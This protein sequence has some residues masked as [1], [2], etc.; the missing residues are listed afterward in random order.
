MKKA[1]VAAALALCFTKGKACAEY[2]P[3]DNY[4]SLFTQS[5]IK[6]KTYLPFLFSW[7]S[8]FYSDGVKRMVPDENIAAWRKYFGN[9]LDYRETEHLVNHMP[10][11]ELQAYKN[12]SGQNAVL[13]KL[14]SYR[15]VAEG[16]DYLLEAKYL[17]PYMKI[18][19]ADSENS[20]YEEPGET[21]KN[22]SNLEYDET[23]ANLTSLY[24][25]AQNREI[26]Q[27]YGYQ[28]VRFHH[29]TR[30]YEQ[31]ISAFSKY[32]E[33]LGKNTVPYFLALD[34]MAGAQRGLA[35]NRE[36]NWNFFRVF[37]NAPS[38]KE[39]AFVS[40]KISDSAAFDNILKKTST[41]E[42]KNMAYFLLGY[43]DFTNP[44]PNMEKMYEIDPKS[45]ILKVMA[46]RT[47]HILEI[48]YLRA[49]LVSDTGKTEEPK[50]DNSV[51]KSATAKSEGFWDQVVGFFQ[52]LFGNKK[53]APA[54]ARPEPDASDEDLTENPNRIP[55]FSSGFIGDEASSDFLDDFSAFTEKTKKASDDEFWQITDAYV[56][57]LQ[58]DYDKSTEVL[59][60]IQTSNPEY[61]EQITRMKMLNR[62]TSQP[63][64]DAA[65]ESQIQKEYPDLFAEK[66]KDS[67][68]KYDYFEEPTT[69]DFIRDVLANRY[70]L[71]NEDG[72]SFLMSNSFSDLQY[73]PDVT[74]T[75]K[76]EEF[77]NKPN[78]TPLEQNIIMQNVDV[79][80]HA[81]FAN[82]IYGDQ[83]MRNGNFDKAK[84]YYAN[85]TGFEGLPRYEW[86]FEQE[87]VQKNKVSQPEGLYDGFNNISPLVFGHNVWESFASSADQSMVAEPFAQEYPFLTKKM[88]KLQLAGALAELKK[89]NT[90]KSNQLIGNVL[91]NTSSLGYFR[92][93]FIMDIDNSPWEKN[94]IQRNDQPK[95]QY[96]Y[97]SYTWQPAVRPDNF[98]VAL[99]FYQNALKKSTDREQKA[100]ILFQMASV[101]QGKYY[102][103]EK[104]QNF[105]EN[106][107]DP[108]WEAKWDEYKQKLGEH[109]NSAYRTYFAQIKNQFA[110]TQTSQ[111]LKGSCSYY[112]YF[113]SK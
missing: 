81:A 82:V 35:M 58:K 94:D 11:A 85:A 33:P 67:A 98:D 44:I 21:N 84:S 6:D 15:T 22:A 37:M 69:A 106:Y 26:K 55:V 99:G 25:A 103:W 40:M 91:Y 60:G 30:N 42:E 107:D 76:V 49:Q 54:E 12:G 48:S 75:R 62:I 3:E 2:Y 111:Q 113:L 4:F 46:A 70:F 105:D 19:F 87:S 47:V 32:V 97:K 39:S 34:Q 53:T 51:K 93:L 14:G 61:Q 88:D 66:E 92:E 83:E 43:S 56:K 18:N 10:L 50:A 73:Y 17:E 74:L 65:F 79:K 102:Q 95:F 89:Q 28:I 29:Y 57:F 71:Q 68:S 90:A 77:I 110:D 45:E 13:N 36:A 23:L 72:K 52:N 24:N 20:F 108:Q 9:R 80:N 86:T 7:G 8:G 5:I 38:R 112:S 31:A 96:Y 104:T 100:R 78:K 109:K 63:K 41:P 16:I 101:E 27:R 64:I 1:F 59:S